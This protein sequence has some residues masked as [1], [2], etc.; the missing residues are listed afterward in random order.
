MIGDPRD[1][2]YE[3]ILLELSCSSSTVAGVKGTH[4]ES[5]IKLS[6]DWS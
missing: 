1:D 5:L 6:V 2:D 3:Y 4:V